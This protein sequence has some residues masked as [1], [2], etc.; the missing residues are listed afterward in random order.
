MSA[1]SR[2]EIADARA[3]QATMLPDTCTVQRKTLVSDGGGGQIERW[4]PV[5]TGVACR[6][7]PASVTSGGGTGIAPGGGRLNDATTHIVTFDAKGDVKLEDRIVVDGDETT[8]E[9]LAIRS[10]GAWEI[11]RHAEVKEA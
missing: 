1:P 4:D 2:A 5:A 6:L 10:G 7:H 3:E 8:Y 11:A 9:V